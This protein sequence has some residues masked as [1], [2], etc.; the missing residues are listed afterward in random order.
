MKSRTLLLLG[1]VLYIFLICELTIR[2]MWF[3]PA[4]AFSYNTFRTLNGNYELVQQSK[5]S[6]VIFEY[7]PS[8]DRP[9][10]TVRYQTNSF[11]MRDKEYSLK[12]PDD[13]FRVAVIGDSLTAGRGVKAES[14]FHSLLEERTNGLPNSALQ[15]EFLNFAVEGYDLRQYAAVLMHKAKLFSPDLILIGLCDNDVYLRSEAEYAKS[16]TP[17]E[18]RTEMQ[19]FLDR[20][21]FYNSF[22]KSYFYLVLREAAKQLTYRNSQEARPQKFREFKKEQQVVDRQF[23]RIAKEAKELQIPVVAIFLRF[24]E[25][26][27]SQLDEIFADVA[28]RYGLQYLDLLPFFEKFEDTRQFHILPWDRHPNDVAHRLYAEILLEYLLEEKLL[29]VSNVENELQVTP[30]RKVLADKIRLTAAVRYH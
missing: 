13:V 9:A 30:L 27:P 2:S 26:G 10:G 23:Q 19:E 24:S 5:I 22:F 6:E 29:P 8:V 11:G 18:P 12:K 25:F 1:T 21:L 3:G 15:F 28:Q 16:Y 7:R 17:K 14:L 20:H 4:V